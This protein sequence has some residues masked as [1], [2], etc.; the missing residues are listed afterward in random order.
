MKKNTRQVAERVH[1]RKLDR[2]IAK[3]Q[4]KK[5]GMRD[6]TNHSYRNT[7]TPSGKNGER[8]RIGSI[9]ADIWREHV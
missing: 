4:M 5:E 7:L 8:I 9:F 2:M 1:T 6:F 3:K